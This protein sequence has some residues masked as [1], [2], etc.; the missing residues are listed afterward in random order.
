M[1]SRRYFR[2][3]SGI[4]HGKRLSAETS[5]EGAWMKTLTV[6]IA[7]VLAAANVIRGGGEC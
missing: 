1:D 6:D 5:V 4:V 2:S 3:H 7:S